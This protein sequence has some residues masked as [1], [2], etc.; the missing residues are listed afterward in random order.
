MARSDWAAYQT[1][2]AA[3]YLAR[4]ELERFGLSPYLPQHRRRYASNGL[5]CLRQYPLFPRYILLPIREIRAPELRAC[6]YRLT[7]LQNEN[8]TVWRAPHDTI[9]SIIEAEHNGRFDEPDPRPGQ[10]VTLT[11]NTVMIP[12]VIAQNLTPSTVEL[13]TPLLGGART[14][15]RADRVRLHNDA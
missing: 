13:F 14:I 8:G 5:W 3:E 6:R 12:G 11:T 9:Q 10:R 2:P 1:E 4:T 15:V 7:L